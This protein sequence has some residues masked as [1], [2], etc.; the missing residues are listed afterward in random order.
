VSNEKFVLDV[1]KCDDIGRKSNKKLRKEGRAPVVLYGSNNEAIKYSAEHKIIVRM[2]EIESVYSQGLELNIEGKKQRVLL[3]EIQR[4]PYKKIIIHLDFLRVE[5]SSVVETSI[6]IH[7]INDKSCFGVKSQGGSLKIATQ[8]VTI[9]SKVSDIPESISL[10]IEELKV[11]QTLHLSDLKFSDGIEIPM[12]R[13]G[14]SHD[15]P[16]VSVAKPGGSS[17]EE[18]GE[19]EDKKEEAAATSE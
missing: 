15:L 6:P 1:V 13:L 12:L 18:D 4:H 5:E 14:K 17:S 8:E 16:I 3:K 10:D 11:T 9:R 7:I 19:E 2:L